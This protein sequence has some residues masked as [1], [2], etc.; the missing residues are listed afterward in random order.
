M[1][2]MPQFVAL[3]LVSVLFLTAAASFADEP[4]VEEHATALEQLQGDWHTWQIFFEHHE[5]QPEGE[6][7][8]RLSLH[9]SRMEYHML[10]SDKPLVVP[11]EFTI[12]SSQWPHRID[13]K[14]LSG[15]YEGQVFHGV[16]EQCGDRLTLCLPDKPSDDRPD[17]FQAM[18]GSMRHVLSLQRDVPPVKKQLADDGGFWCLESDE[19]CTTPR[20]CRPRAKK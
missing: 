8:F 4:V 10:V 7:G 16:F 20:V 6:P 18:K 15:A 13:A 3:S 2:V 1:P 19:C 12:D 14:I 9:G 5:L 17:S 11:F